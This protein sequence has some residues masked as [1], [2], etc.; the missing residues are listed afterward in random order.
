MH[1]PVLVNQQFGIRHLEAA[2]LMPS[3]FSA[4]YHFATIE[5]ACRL[6]R[7]EG[8]CMLSLPPDVLS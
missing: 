8:A 7:P 2:R 1:A 4:Q 6:V 3:R 5:N